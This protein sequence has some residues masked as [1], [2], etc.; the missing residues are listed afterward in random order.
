MPAEVDIG[1]LRSEMESQGLSQ[2]ELVNRSGV[3]RAQVSRLL[4]RDRA[5]VRDQTIFRLAKG[6]AIDI[7]ELAANGRHRQYLDWVAEEHGFVDFRGM[8]MPQFRR[9]QIEDV[10]VEPD[11]LGTDEGKKNEYDGPDEATRW[12]ESQPQKALASEII[13]KLDRLVV[14]GHPGN[15]KTTLLRW[16]AYR[17][18]CGKLSGIDAKAYITPIYIRLADFS[19]AL[20]IDP[21]TELLKFTSS[22]TAKRGCPHIEDEL[23]AKLESN[24]SHCLVLLDGLDEVGDEHRR[25]GLVEAISKFIKAYPRNRFILT[26]RRVGFES[27]P[28][29]DLGFSVV[30]LLGYG[31]KQLTEFAAK[32][33]KLLPKVFGGT[34]A[35]A[36]ESL[37]SAIFGNPRVRALASNP[38]VLTILAL[39]N[40]SR[41]GALPRRRVD[42]Y[43]KVVEVFLETWESTKQSPE[44]FDETSDID[45]DARE[46]GWLLSDLALAMQR[47]DRTLAARWWI[48]DRVQDCLQQKLGFEIE[49]AK[50]AGERILRYLTE[51]TG[52]IAERGL[53]QFGFSHRTLQEYFAAMGVIDEADTSTSRDV[54]DHL[55]GY[56]F[57]PQWSEVV[58]LVAAKV[59]PPIAESMISTILDDPDPVGR[60]LLRRGPILALRCLSDGATVPNRRLV[61]G[62]FQSLTVLGRS[63]WL[64]V[65][66]EALDVLDT[67]EGTRLESEAAH[68]INTILEMAQR[69]LDPDE[70]ACLYQTAHGEEVFEQ[71]E[72]DLGS[73][74]QDAARE[75]KVQVTGRT[76]PIVYFNAS[77]RLEQPDKWFKSVCSLVQDTTQSMRFRKVLIHELGRQIETHA[78]PR[79]ALR[80]LVE[81]EMTPELRAEAAE[82]LVTS[83]SDSKLLFRVLRRNNEEVRVRQACAS[84]LRGVAVSDPAVAAELLRM[85]DSETSEALRIGAA[86]GLGKVAASDE[87]VANALLGVARGEDTSDNL[88]AACAWALE[89][90]IGKDGNVRAFFEECLNGNEESKL[91]RVAA[92]EL[93]DSLADELV[94]WDHETI[95]KVQAILM[96]L[97]DPCPHA[98][99]SLVAIATARE[100]RCGLRLENVLRDALQSIG[101]QVELAFVFGS[102]AR[103]R[104]TPESDIDLMIIGDVSQK[105]L[106]SPLRAAEKTLGRR[107]NPVPHTRIEIQRKYQSGD[108][109]LLDVY[110]REKIPIWPMGMSRKDLEDEFRTMV[111]ERLASTG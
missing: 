13:L 27:S 106:S 54:S 80:K 90:R 3:S 43:A 49:Q 35:K 83:T 25:A 65:T 105:S 86:R 31:Q 66:F 6:L 99:T 8:G 109:F 110:R 15:G 36:K 92:Q 28:W 77:L 11:V 64:G 55:R 44:I 88:K 2:A 79:R 81:S 103:K 71:V 76:V 91:R 32:W 24:T 50:D 98:L 12:R 46:F 87:Q 69:E 5:T 68:T 4:S 95:E 97:D 41:G 1:R 26:S 47:N 39:L 16:L 17:A 29:T 51:R 62:I 33:A 85:L 18:A 34:E 111:A 45:L 57:N 100:V 108:A 53:D 94:E 61:S 23:R 14:V 63:K 101:N 56:F 37:S 21:K 102:T 74:F 78:S 73:N 72:R 10:F 59:T 107:I 82:A 40:E 7:S 48:T 30:R 60:D 19:R 104:Q 75:V 96:S 20:E 67:F 70:Y 93:A 38:L 42:L 89:E 52:L 58:R 9:Q 22:I 84:S